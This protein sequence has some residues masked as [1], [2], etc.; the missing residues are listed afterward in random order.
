MSVFNSVSSA[1]VY[2]M[3]VLMIAGGVLGL[4]IS[5][6]DLF[7]PWTSKAE[8]ERI[9]VDTSH[10]KNI[11]Q[12]EERRLHADIDNYIEQK[13]VEL[14][15]EKA[16]AKSDLEYQNQKNQIILNL[17][18]VASEGISLAVGFLGVAVPVCLV[19][20]SIGFSIKLTRLSHEEVFTDSDLNNTPNL[21][22]DW[23]NPTYKQ[24]RIAKAK[25]NEHLYNQIQKGNIAVR[26]RLN[27]RKPITWQDLLKPNDK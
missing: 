15:K 26:S 24:N 3:L 5:D 12:E 18:S 21:I 7:N 14:E 13:R 23:K 8:A 25:K 9:G 22:E 11:H 2:L 27:H 6:T 20:V 19:V 4:A 16:L 17:L 10:Q 1:L